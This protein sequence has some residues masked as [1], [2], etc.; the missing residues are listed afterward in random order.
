MQPRKNFVLLL[1]LAVLSSTLAFGK[2][3]SRD[4]QAIRALD[5]PWSQAAGAKDLDQTLSFYADD[6]SMLPAN[7]PIAS[8]KDAIHTAWSHFN[9]PARFLAEL[10]PK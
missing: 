10:R 2:D 7:A 4:E 1:V 6:A 3:A 8:G 5:A 9:G